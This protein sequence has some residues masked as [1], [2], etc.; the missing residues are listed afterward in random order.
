EPLTI[1]M[2]EGKQVKFAISSAATGQPIGGA[3]VRF[4]FPDRR[5]EQADG[6]GVVVVQGLMPIED[7]YDVTVEAEGYA[8][9][10]QKINL[11][12]ASGIQESKVALSPGGIVR[13]AV[14]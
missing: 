12:T 6:N 8:R 9:A 3:T 4:G 1:E 10:A 13:G 5:A 7:E 11:A 14:V 2:T